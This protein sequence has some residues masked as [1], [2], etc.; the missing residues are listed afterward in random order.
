MIIRRCLPR[1]AACH[2]AAP[3]RSWM[4]SERYRWRSGA[5]A[6]SDGTRHKR[7]PSERPLMR[8]I[9]GQVLV[10]AE[11]MNYL[12]HIDGEDIDW[13]PGR[14]KLDSKVLSSPAIDSTS[15]EPA[16]QLVGCAT[17]P[18]PVLLTARGESMQDIDALTTDEQSY[19]CSGSSWCVKRWLDE[20]DLH[21]HTSQVAEQHGLC[22]SLWRGH[23]QLISTALEANTNIDIHHMG[24]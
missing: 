18:T 15:I 1:R 13:Q 19:T 10:S 14:H 23:Q 17:P 2:R 12:W 6:G 7:R 11:I 9:C 24:R 20:H 3:C 16:D 8:T 21:Q 5:G 22:S 4:L